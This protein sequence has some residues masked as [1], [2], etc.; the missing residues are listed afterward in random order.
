M[1][2][3]KLFPFDKEK[4][5][6]LKEYNFG[7]NWP[8]VYLITDGSKEIYIGET[9]SMYSRAH[10]H[11]E[12][13]ERKKLKDLYVISD[14]EYNKSAALDIESMLIQYIS[15]DGKLKLQNGNK[16]LLNHNYFD[17]D[18]YRAKF[19]TI[20]KQLTDL[21]IVHNPLVQIKN[22]DLFKYSP[23]KALTEDQINVV[24]KL[25]KEI[26]KGTKSNFI[27]NGGPGT[28]KTILAIYL[29]KSLLETEET[30]H[31]KIGLVIPMTSL[32]ETVKKVFRS[33]KGLSAKMIIGPGDVVKE[34]Y[35][36]LIVD[37][38]H[39]LKQRKNIVNYESFDKT[40]KI[41]GLN[42]SGTELDWIIK[43]S[44]HRIFFYDKNQSVRP[45][46]VHESQFIK[47]DAEQYE[48]KSQ[49]RIAGGLGTEGERYIKF[50]EN[51]FDLK[52]KGLEK[53]VS[54]E[55]KVFDDIKLMVDEVKKKDYAYKGL[56]RMVSG[57]AWPWSSK[58]DPSKHDI[59]IQGTKLF[60]N[61]VTTDWVNSRNAIN[62]V[63]CIHTVQ[64]YDLNF[65]GVI[66]GPEITYDKIKNKI[67]IRAENYFDM[68][69]RR[70]VEDPLEL[71]RYIINIY[72]TLLTRG[73]YGTYVYI[74][75]NDLREYIKS[76]VVNSHNPIIV[77]NHI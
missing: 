13:Q 8:V 10:Q 25:L 70:G 69:G 54:Y 31:L 32:R 56:S 71:E 36:I 21:K 58:N 18:K 3:I 19:E 62:E 61:S 67:S 16:G 14:E 28:G 41:L 53:F 55:F 42:N 22:S 4:F 17:R 52:Q 47:L 26:S 39:R 59:E 64:G 40:N 7:K 72:K 51:L 50:I 46:D 9:T 27:I 20:W 66:I 37:E 43:S 15:G 76:H 60:W 57:Y 30:K 63:G 73:I 68:N 29:V 33:I 1:S 65:A 74:V 12:N 75:D 23:Y 11:F 24:E 35:D 5:S 34:K 44:K 38:S 2:K 6:N 77:K 45:S 48:L 49:L